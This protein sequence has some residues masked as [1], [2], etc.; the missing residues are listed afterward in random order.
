ME[1][2]KNE[3]ASSNKEIF[4]VIGVIGGFLTLGILSS[5]DMPIYAIVGALFGIVW[6]GVFGYIIKLLR[7][8][9]KEL[10]K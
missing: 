5:T 6:I 8:I 1:Q 7:D 2:E 10:R 3:P 4:V 9:L